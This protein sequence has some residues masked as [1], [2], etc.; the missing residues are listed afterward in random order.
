MDFE[1]MN[2]WYRF[3]DNWIGIAGLCM[4][5]FP[6]LLVGA[7]LAKDVLGVYH[8]KLKQET[9]VIT[10]EDGSIVKDRLEVYRS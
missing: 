9:A 3:G 6:A 10:R 1:N 5:G 8:S 4:I 2:F 7:D